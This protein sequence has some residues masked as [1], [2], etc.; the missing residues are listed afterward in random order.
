[1]VTLS[2]SAL[3]SRKIPQCETHS[4]PH[5]A[6]SPSNLPRAHL[7]H[8]CCPSSHWLLDSG[9]SHH[10]TN[11]LSNLSLH[12]PYDGTED[13]VI[14]NGTGISITHIGSLTLSTI[15]FKP[16]ILHNILCAPTMSHNILSISQL[17][18]QNDLLIEFSS[19]SFVLKDH[20]TGAP[21]L[22][23]PTTHGVYK[24]TSTPT[25]SVATTITNS[26]PLWHHKLG[27]PSISILKSLASRFNINVY[28]FNS[29]NSC[30]AC[31]CNRS[32]KLPFHQSTIRSYAP[33]DVILY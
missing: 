17:C 25:A 10:I 3:L 27:H 30:D 23:G 9:A 6:N 13:I 1:M 32:H 2:T 29:F 5:G 20:L 24:L 8:F 14:G 33:L 15:S 19:F 21:L 11:D 4:S 26:A 18:A 31:Q 16:I 12:Y 22:N 7:A 28:D